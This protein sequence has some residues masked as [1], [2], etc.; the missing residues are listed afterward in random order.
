VKPLLLLILAVLLGGCS[1]LF[2]GTPDEE[3]G[4]PEDGPVCIEITEGY[5]VGRN[6][7]ERLVMRHEGYRQHPYDDNGNLSVGY[8]RNLTTNGISEE[9]ALYLLRNDLDRIEKQL[10][11]KYPVTSELSVDRYNVVV[12]MAYVLG[13]NG[14]SKFKDFWKALEHRDYPRAS[15]EIYLSKFC[16]DIGRRC[17][18]LAEMMWHGKAE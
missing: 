2:S 13:M 14:L 10:Q 17:P 5:H 15:V 3:P 11:E 12:S 6:K 1:T 7:L 8:A 16:N 4:C 18:E 9:E